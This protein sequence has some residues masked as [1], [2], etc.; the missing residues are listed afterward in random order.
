[1]SNS[2][3][4]VVA[5]EEKQILADVKDETTGEE[6]KVPVK[7]KKIEITV[8]SRYNDLPFNFSK[9]T[10]AKFWT[11]SRD[12]SKVN[13]AYMLGEVA[14]IVSKEHAADAKRQIQEIA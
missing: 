2:A 1:M 10:K 5:S 6:I 11:D 9:T 3:S 4:I 12:G 7:H 14:R 13:E 8:Q